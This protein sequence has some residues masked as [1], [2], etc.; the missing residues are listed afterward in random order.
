MSGPCKPDEGFL[1]LISGTWLYCRRSRLAFNLREKACPRFEFEERTLPAIDNLR[2]RT[3]LLMVKRDRFATA[4]GKRGA[5]N[6]PA[7][8]ARMLQEGFRL[9]TAGYHST[10]ASD[11]KLS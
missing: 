11:V 9:R 4:A 2:V 5:S 3:D 7:S 10:R 6:A 8:F 1:P